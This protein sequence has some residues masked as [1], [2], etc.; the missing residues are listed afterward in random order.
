M[1]QVTAE[2]YAPVPWTLAAHAEVWVVRMD[3]GVQATETEVIAVGTATATAAEPDLVASCVEVAVMV[4]A[5]A[6]VGVKTPAAVIL[7]PIADQVT[8]ELYAPVPWTFAEQTEVWVVRIEAGAHTTD[9]EVIA[10]GTAAVTTADPDLVASWVEVAVMFAV[11]AVVGVKRP[12][13]VMVPPVADQAT[14]E[15]SA[16]TPCT[17]AEH[18]LE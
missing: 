1:D 14:A 15:L 16:P 4:A 12:E 11:P 18:W 5:P 8:P 7:P 2:L 13:E 6:V 10:T 9:T 3:A 17:D